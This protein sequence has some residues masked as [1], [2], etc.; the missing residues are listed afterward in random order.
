MNP[1]FAANIR[2]IVDKMFS[3]YDKETIGYIEEEVNKARN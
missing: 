1:Q 2:N 3:D